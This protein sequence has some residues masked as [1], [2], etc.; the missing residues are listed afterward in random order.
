MSSRPTTE[1]ASRSSRRPRATRVCCRRPITAR[2]DVLRDASRQIYVEAGC[3][4]D[5]EQAMP[6]LG[7]RVGRGGAPPGLAIAG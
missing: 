6:E 7:L 2:R 1:P 3:M 5:V 4:A